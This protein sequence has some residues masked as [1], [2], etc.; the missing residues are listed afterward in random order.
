MLLQVLRV[1]DAP[2]APARARGG[3]ADPRRRHAPQ[4]QGAAGP[5]GRGARPPP[6]RQEEA[7]RARARR[8]H[9][10]RRLGLRARARARAAPAHQ[11]RRPVEGGPGAPA[12][13]DRLAGADAGVDQPRPGRPPGLADQAPRGA[14]RDH[15]RRRRAEDPVHE[16]DPGRDRRDRGGADRGARG[17]RRV[18]P[19]PG[20]H[21][22]ELRPAPELL[23]AG[24]GRDRR[25]GVEGVLAHRDRPR[26][27]ARPPE[28]GDAGLAR[29]H[30]APDR[31]GEA[32]AAG[33][34]HP[35]AAQP[36][37]LVAGARR[38]GRD[39]PRR[40]VRQRRPHLARAPVPVPAQGPQA[41]RAG[42]RGADRAAVRLRR[43]HRPRVGRPG[44]ARRHQDEVL[45][46]HPAPRLRPPPGPA[47]RPPSRPRSSAPAPACCSAATR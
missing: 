43:V 38:R 9:R 17:A 4:R 8:L 28:V 47:A 12:R 42:R 41:A 21:P 32:A 25:G 46:L 24:A 15:P 1:R 45:E 29:R 10:L 31:R 23:R 34:R 39:R 30:E 7:R 20:G 13:G 3:R 35:G 14:A 26:P 44:R 18:R 2:A 40:A 16:R 33:R 19:H 5:D 36:R 22:P 6:G 37:R 11:P 27:A